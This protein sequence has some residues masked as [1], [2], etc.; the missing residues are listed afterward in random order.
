MKSKF[1]HV[2]NLYDIRRLDLLLF[3]SALIF[4]FL[5]RIPT[6]DH[7]YHQDEYKWAINLRELGLDSLPHPPLVPF[8]FDTFGNFFGFQNLRIVVL[9]FSLILFLAQTVAVAKYLDSSTAAIFA[10]AVAINPYAAIMSTQIDIDG[11]FLPLIQTFFIVLLIKRSHK[12]TSANSLL[13]FLVIILG[14]FIKLSFIISVLT[15]AFSVFLISSLR[16]YRLLAIQILI[17]SVL[18]VLLIQNQFSYTVSYVG[19]FLSGNFFERSWSQVII[20]L[21]KVVLLI[22]PLILVFIFRDAMVSKL[23]KVVSI[24]TAVNLIWYLIIFDF[25]ERAIDRYLQSL[26]YPGILLFSYWCSKLLI[27][28]YLLR[29]AVFLVSLMFVA[30]PILWASRDF[31][32]MSLHPKNLYIERLLTF[33]LNFLFPLFTASGPL[34]FFISFNF[35]VVSFMVSLV[36]ILVNYIPRGNLVSSQFIIALVTVYS[37]TLSIEN[38]TGVL[39]GDSNAVVK[40]LVRDIDRNQRVLTYNDIAAYELIEKGSYSGRLYMRPDWQESKMEIMRNFDDFFMYVNMPPIDSA[41]WLFEE[42]DR[43][44]ITSE[45]A[46]GKIVGRLYDCRLTLRD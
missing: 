28:G 42:L 3:G 10:F 25:S 11:T 29:T 43:C 32:T 33:D 18:I 30:L 26:T 15:F 45:D 9:M 34:G 27:K 4:W 17:A 1:A 31:D 8:I 23:A 46:D 40:E 44:S 24:W 38:A 12:K 2:L 6:L 21:S 22:G 20:L 19:N 16:S 35:L 14:Y 36:L 13:L 7:V 5:L 41:K 39:Y 37:L